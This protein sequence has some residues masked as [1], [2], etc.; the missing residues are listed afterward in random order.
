L[1]AD[2]ALDVILMTLSNV[3]FLSVCVFIMVIL[4][5]GTMLKCGW[6]PSCE[7]SYATSAAT[8]SVLLSFFPLRGQGLSVAKQRPVFVN[9]LV[10]AQ[11]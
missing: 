1:S 4:C 7:R 9:T 10:P 11:N 3:Q 5:K 2:G 8:G 6:Q